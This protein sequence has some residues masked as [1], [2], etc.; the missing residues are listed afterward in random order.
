MLYT[1]VIRHISTF[2]NLKDW[3]SFK[4]SCKSNNNDLSSMPNH[5]IPMNENPIDFNVFLSNNKIKNVKIDINELSKLNKNM[6]I[7]KLYITGNT[8][9][10]FKYIDLPTTLK[11]IQFCKDFNQSID[12]LPQTLTHLSFGKAF[13][14]VLDLRYLTNLTHIVFGRRYNQPVDKLPVS[15]TH[16]VFGILF[17]QSVENLPSSL[18]YLKFTG[19]FNQPLNNLPISLKHLTVGYFFNQS[20]VN[21]PKTLNIIYNNY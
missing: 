19:I 1:D 10:N 4:I 15:L 16:L 2:V 3:I 7:R 12:N 20:T 9:I 6:K 5:Q 17:N 18:I 8:P 13:N 11:E 21:L 14:Q